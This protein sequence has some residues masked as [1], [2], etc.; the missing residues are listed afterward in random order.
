MRFF[1][2]GAPDQYHAIASR[3]AAGGHQRTTMRLIA[4]CIIAVTVPAL[5]AMTNP[6]A[7]RLPVRGAATA[8]VVVAG[9]GLVIP[10]LRSRWPTRAESVIAVAVATFLLAA[11]C[12]LAANPLVGLLTATAFAFILGYTALFHGT[13]LQV[14]VAAVAALT[15]LWLTVRIATDGLSTAL[16]VSTP[17]VML[18]AAVTVVWRTLGD[19]AASGVS[20]AAVEPLTGLPTRES[21]D[22]LAATVLGA[23][24]RDDDRF[25]VVA[26]LGIDSVPARLSLQGRRSLDQVRAAVAQALRDTVRRD[27]VVGHLTGTEFLIADVFTTPDPIPLAERI[28]GSVAA[29]PGGVTASIGVVSTPL[30]PLA[31][32]PAHEVLDEALALATAAMARAR[33]RGG[34]QVDCS[35]EPTLGGPAEPDPEPGQ[36]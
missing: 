31:G 22:E 9:L 2:P 13:V 27:A 34:N 16:A 11:G 26:A 23:R 15:V 5:L 35:L 4:G 17:V 8:A 20:R 28:R 21:V 32:R 14:C 36:I 25:L 1:G 24:T 7:T 33:R 6:A 29:I 30:R 12:A 19:M 18:I 3:I 10:W